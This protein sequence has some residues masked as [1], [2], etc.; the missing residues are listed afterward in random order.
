MARFFFAAIMVCSSAQLLVLGLIG[1]YLGRLYLE[2]K[3]RPLFIIEEIVG[4]PHTLET[5]K[6]IDAESRETELDNE[7]RAQIAQ[8]ERKL[9]NLKKAS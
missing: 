1:E 5:S 4:E 8:L 9:L 3:G 6:I 7:V 2:A